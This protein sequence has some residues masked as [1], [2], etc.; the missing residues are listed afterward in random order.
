[1]RRLALQVED[2]SI[3]FGAFEGVI[4]KGQY[5]A[6]SIEIWDSGNYVLHEWTEQRIEVTLEGSRIAGRYVMTR[7]RRKGEREW[8]LWRKDS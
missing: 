4:P 8:L 3:E 6:G 2:H 5:G 1:M 7:F